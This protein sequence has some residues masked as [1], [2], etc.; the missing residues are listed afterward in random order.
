[1]PKTSS[2]RCMTKIP[3]FLLC[4]QCP[5][6]HLLGLSQ[7]ALIS[8]EKA[9]VVDGAECGCMLR[10]ACFLFSLQCPLVHLL[11]AREDLPVLLVD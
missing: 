7:L 4:L 6:V 5:L 9:Q 3:C 2:N 10:A 11:G 8:I 1:M